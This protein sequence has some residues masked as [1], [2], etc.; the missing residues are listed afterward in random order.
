MSIGKD[1]SKKEQYLEDEIVRLRFEI[2][3]ADDA[4]LSKSEIRDLKKKLKMH[5]KQL[6]IL[7]KY[8]FVVEIEMEDEAEID[9]D[10]REDVRE[11]IEISL[12]NMHDI[13]KAKVI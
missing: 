9:F 7:R 12:Q 2:D 8:K 4:Y 1:T 6:K 10:N 11:Y 5:Q 13:K 3:N